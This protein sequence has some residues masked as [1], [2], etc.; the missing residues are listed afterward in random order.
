MVAYALR[1]FLHLKVTPETTRVTETQNPD[2]VQ[3]GD[4]TKVTTATLKQVVWYARK[5]KKIKYAAG[6]PCQDNSNL[7]G[8]NRRGLKGEK[9]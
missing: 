5:C 1:H 3:F 4:I 9:S 2:D 7:K 8:T 6:S